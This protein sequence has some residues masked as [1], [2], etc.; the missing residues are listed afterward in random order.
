MADKTGKIELIKEILEDVDE[1]KFQEEEVI[2][3]LL[4]NKVSKN[5]SQEHA[6]ELTLSTRMADGIAQFVGSWKFIMIFVSCLICWIILNAI[7]NTKAIDPYPFILLNLI[8]SCVAAIQAPVIMMSQNRQEEKDR[9]RSLN[10]YKTNLKAEI[11]LEDMHLKMDQ[12]LTN[13]QEL[14]Q[15]LSTV[16]KRQET[17]DESTEN[18]HD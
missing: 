10:D 9:S 12:I 1:Q 17:K 2:H 11:I 7:M 8:L 4:D 5:I 14:L 15:R 13:Q 18:G 16:E 6:G 3:F